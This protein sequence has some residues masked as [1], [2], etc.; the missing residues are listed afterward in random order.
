MRDTHQQAMDAWDKAIRV[1]ADDA[2]CRHLDF[3]GWC[4]PAL[5]DRT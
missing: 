4:N 2:P 1:L 3:C 5:K